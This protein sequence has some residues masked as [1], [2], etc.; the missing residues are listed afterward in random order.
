MLINISSQYFLEINFSYITEKT[1]LKLIKYNKALQKIFDISL[2]NY[3][4][5]SG[6]YIVYKSQGKGRE[7]NGYNNILKYEGELLNGE[8]NGKGKKY[9]SK[10]GTIKFEGEYLRGKKWNGKEKI[11]DSDGALIFEAEYLNGKKWNA[12][13][14][15]ENNVYEIKEGKG[16][17]KELDI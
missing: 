7:F 1:K 5:F 13:S 12:K 15:E 2:V 4:F 3:K 16:F 14:Y 17:I 11:Y 6:K 10:D 9:N 8:R